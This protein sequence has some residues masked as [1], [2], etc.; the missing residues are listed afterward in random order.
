[1]SEEDSKV[2]GKAIGAKA[3]A[4][5]LTPEQRS[6]IARNAALARHN[7]NKTLEAIRKGNF[8]DDFGLDIDCYVLNDDQNT[9]VISQRGMAAAIGFTG[10]GGNNLSRFI[11]RKSIAPY[12]G[13]ELSQK[14]LNPIVFKTD[15]GGS[16]DSVAPRAHGYDVTILIDLCN[17]IIEADNAGALAK[18]QKGIA[19]QAKVITGASA[20][21]G[22]QQLVYKLSGFDSTK[23]QFIQAFKQFVNDEA[24]K[25]EKEFPIELYEEWARL[26]SLT[27]PDRGWPWDFRHLTVKHVYYPLAKSRGKLLT[28]LREAKGKDGDSKKKLFQFLNEIGTRALRMHLGRLL[29]MAESSKTKEEYEKKIIDRFGGQ[30]ALCASAT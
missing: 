23:E 22:I 21:S 18:S 6:E 3:R 28:L 11:E 2:T 14:I 7:A 19:Q 4:E 10:K 1:M 17:A 15:K 27:I 8:I 30:F 24:K 13:S 12:I 16:E 25:Y 20:K 29:E 5:K 9:A 26:Y